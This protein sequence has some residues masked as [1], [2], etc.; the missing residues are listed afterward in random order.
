[1]N[2][3]FKTNEE[4]KMVEKPISDNI[5]EPLVGAPQVVSPTPTVNNDMPSEMAES[6]EVE[7]HQV[8]DVKPESQMPK[9]KPAKKSIIKKILVIALI[10]LLVLGGV[11]AFWWRDMTAKDSETKQ[12]AIIATLQKSVTSL[13]TELAAAKGTTAT[14]VTTG[15]NGQTACTSIAPVAATI[16]NIKASITS[17]NT[18]ALEGYMATSVNVV[19]ADTGGIVSGTPTQAVS[20]ITDFI[21]SATSPWNFALSSSVLS[22]Y[23]AGGFGK[24]FPSIAVVGL[25]ANNKVVSFNFD[26]EGKIS[27]VLLSPNASLLE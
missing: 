21:T 24:Y 26:C 12:A 14:S 16:D 17:G 7:Q 19:L 23:T 1:M 15:V 9:N 5:S 27:S 18:A 20:S 6:L 4:D 11:A 22:K 2:P 13:T 25:S 8:N 10:V 3:E